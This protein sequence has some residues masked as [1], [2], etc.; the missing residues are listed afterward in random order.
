VVD[1]ASVD[2][3]WRVTLLRSEVFQTDAAL[4]ARSLGT[5][6]LLTF[7]VTN[8]SSGEARAVYMLFKPCEGEGQ[9]Q[10]EGEGEGEAAAASAATPECRSEVAAYEVASALGFGAHVPPSFL[11]HVARDRYFEA[12][13]ELG[14]ARLLSSVRRRVRPRRHLGEGQP[15]TVLGVM[16]WVVAPESELVDA[17]LDA[18]CSRSLRQCAPPLRAALA[19]VR[20]FD[21]LI[22][23]DDRFTG[24]NLKQRRG[25]V[26]GAT[27]GLVWLDHDMADVAR[28]FHSLAVFREDEELY[29]RMQLSIQQF[30]LSTQL[31]GFCEFSDEL[32]AR[33]RGLL[34][35]PAAAGEGEGEGEGERP[36][37]VEQAGA[38]LGTRLEAAGLGLHEENVERLKLRMRLLL[39]HLDKCD[40]RRER[41]EGAARPAAVVVGLEQGGEGHKDPL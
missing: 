18:N 10:G 22:G 13:E 19:D 29:W 36:I 30:K 6:L 15:Q 5:K 14:N 33:I 35:P 11:A 21:F 8:A 9:G 4:K 1:E 27:Q 26:A 32:R 16:Q 34:D 12:F 40:A 28:P 20:V 25:D 24:G 31:D 38:A 2:D 39:D 37:G 7:G 23:N 3:E 41:G 17:E